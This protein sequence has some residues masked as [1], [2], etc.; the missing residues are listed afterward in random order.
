MIMVIVFENLSNLS[1]P[2]I[3]QIK[4]DMHINNVLF[5]ELLNC[6]IIRNEKKNFNFYYYI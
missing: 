2:Q 5:L 1:P 3:K 6:I 4:F